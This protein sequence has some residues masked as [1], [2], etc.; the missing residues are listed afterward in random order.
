M[1][2]LFFAAKKKLFKRV[3]KDLYP[4]KW[5]KLLL[6]EVISQ[7]CS[8]IGAE[9]RGGLDDAPMFSLYLPV[10]RNFPDSGTM[11]KCIH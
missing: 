3:L 5:R 10:T 4:A 11:V 7:R 2:I 9:I 1:D 8:A 6:R